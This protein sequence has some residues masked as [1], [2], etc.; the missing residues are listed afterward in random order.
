MSRVTKDDLLFAY[1]LQ[2]FEQARGT[3]VSGACRTFGI[4]A[5]PTTPGRSRASGLSATSG[6]GSVSAV[7]NLSDRLSGRFLCAVRPAASAGRLFEC[8]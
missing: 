8:L 6:A 5:R 2:V 3:S 1:R 4:T 7:P